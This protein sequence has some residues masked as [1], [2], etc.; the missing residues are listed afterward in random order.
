M[1][2][3]GKKTIEI[4]SKTE[5]GAGASDKT[6]QR[7]LLQNMASYKRAQD[8]AAKALLDQS[9]KVG[10][11]I[12]QGVKELMKT[13]LGGPGTSKETQE[14]KKAADKQAKSADKV[15]S[16]VDGLGKKVDNLISVIDRDIKGRPKYA[17]GTIAPGVTHRTE[18]VDKRSKEIADS[19]DKI[20]K[21]LKE[22][23]TSLITSARK[24]KAFEG[25]L[26]FAAPPGEKEPRLVRGPQGKDFRLEV[27][28]LDKLYKAID[29]LDQ[30]LR[31]QLPGRGEVTPEKVTK[32]LKAFESRL[33]ERATKDPAT[34]EE[35]A[36]AVAKVLQRQTGRR[37]TAAKVQEELTA[38]EI[39]RRYLKEVIPASIQKQLKE[40]V[41]TISVPAIKRTE[42]GL[43]VIET[44]SGAERGVGQFAYFKRGYEQLITTLQR[45]GK[46]TKDQ[47][48]EIRKE[49]FKAQ[50]RPGRG[51][52]PV[53]QE[54]L[55]KPFQQL[56]KL[57]AA[58]KPEQIQQAFARAI[59]TA[60]AKKKGGISGEEFE[61]RVAALSKKD[62]PEL[63]A[64]L[65]N[66]GGSVV[67]AVNALN[68]L[69]ELNL[70]D[71]LQSTLRRRV[72]QDPKKRTDVLEDFWRRMGQGQESAIRKLEQ[73]MGKLIQT[74]P[75][76]SPTKP[77]TGAVAEATVGVLTRKPG[78]A[79]GKGRPPIETTQLAPAAKKAAIVAI[80]EELRGYFAD[81]EAT[82]R[83]AESS[84]QRLSSI[85][86]SEVIA[87]TITN[88]EQ[89]YSAMF[90]MSA[91]DLR[92]LGPFGEQF[93]NLGRSL[94]QAQTAIS[95]P[96]AELPTLRSRTEQQFIESGRLGRGGFGYNV[97]TE[98]RHTAGTFEDQIEIAGKLAKV[99]T[100][101]ARKLV[102]PGGQEVETVEEGKIL[103]ESPL[104][105]A[106]GFIQRGE[107]IPKEILKEISDIGNEIITAFG[108]V[109]RYEFGAD[110]AFIESVVQTAVAARGEEVD[111]QI[112]KIV[113]QFVAQWGRKFTTRFAAKGVSTFGVGEAAA[114]GARIK[115]AED[116]GVARMPKT[117][118]ELASEMLGKMFP[119]AHE[120]LRKQL[121]AAGNK[122]FI[123]LFT[124]SE[125]EMANLLAELN[126]ALGESFAPDP[127]SIN[128]F[129]EMFTEKMGAGAEALY[130]EV[131]IEARISASGLVKRGLQSDILEQ[132]ANN[133]TGAVETVIPDKVDIEKWLGKGGVFA[134]YLGA[135]GFERNEE[136]IRRLTSELEKT[137]SEINEL[138]A[139]EV[140][141]DRKRIVQLQERQAQLQRQID[142]E[143]TYTAYSQVGGARRLVGE[144][145]LEIVEE[146]R[147][148]REATEREL[149]VGRKGLPIN[150][151]A[152]AAVQ[153]IFGESSAYMKELAESYSIGEAQ[154][155]ELITAVFLMSTQFKDLQGALDQA[156]PTIEAGGDAIAVF[157]KSA[158]DLEDIKDTILDMAKFPAAFGLQLPEAAGG[159]TLFVPGAVARGTYQEPETGRI[160]PAAITRYLD[161]MVE[162]SKKI[163]D[164]VTGKGEI[165]D[166]EQLQ[167]NVSV[168]FSRAINEIGDELLKAVKGEEVNVQ[169]AQEMVAKLIATLSET[170]AVEFTIRGDVKAKTERAAVEE[171]IA[172]RQKELPKKGF[173]VGGQEIVEPSE[174]AAALKALHEAA[175]VIKDIVVSPRGPKL[176]ADI[177]KI[178]AGI[179]KKRAKGEAVS[180]LESIEKGL[181][182]RERATAALE[183][184]DPA[185]VRQIGEILG[186]EVSKGV[187]TTFQVQLKRLATARAGYEKELGKAIFGK[188]GLVQT[189]LLEK[190]LP[191]VRGQVVALETDKIDDLNKAIRVMENVVDKLPDSAKN[192]VEAAAAI[193]AENIDKLRKVVEEA[194]VR[195]EEALA[196]GKPLL[197]EGEIAISVERAAKLGI[198]SALEE[199][200][201]V[202]V[203]TL[204]FPVTGAPSFQAAKARLITEEEGFAAPGFAEATFGL[205]GRPGY[206]TAEVLRQLEPLRKVAGGLR[207]DL[208]DLNKAVDDNKISEKEAAP[209]R[210]E[211]AGALKSL[212][213]I[214]NKATATFGPFEQNLDFDG[215]AIHVHAAK[216]K[217]AANEIEKHYLAIRDLTN[218]TMAVRQ[219]LF[220]AT[221][222]LEEP[223]VETL[224]QM[225]E[226]FEKRF[227]AVKGF[228]FLARPHIQEQVADIPTEEL[229]RILAAYTT[230]A[231]EKV[232]D[233]I[234]KLAGKLGKE[235]GA[236][237][238]EEKRAEI[239]NRKVA[240]DLVKHLSRTDVAPATEQLT[241]IARA[242]ESSVGFGGGL[243][244]GRGAGGEPPYAGFGFKAGAVFGEDPATAFQNRLNEILRFGINAAL[245]TKHGGDPVY[246]EFGVLLTKQFS[247]GQIKKTLADPAYG[248]LQKANEAIE[249]TIRDR[250]RGLDLE[251]IIE[252]AKSLGIEDVG[253]KSRRELVDAL[254]E[255]ANLVGFI[256]E[257]YKA[258]E[259]SAIKAQEVKITK[260]P[261]LAKK[262][263]TP[264]ERRAEAERRFLKARETAGGKGFKRIDVKSEITEILEPL[265]ILRTRGEDL[266]TTFAKLNKKADPQIFAPDWMK[267]FQEQAEE[268][269]QKLDKSYVKA[270]GKVRVAADHLVQSLLDMASGTTATGDALTSMINKFFETSEGMIEKRAR[271]AEQLGISGIPGQA[272][273]PEVLR[274]RLKESLIKAT[275]K[276]PTPQQFEKFLSSFMK[277]LGIEDIS[278][279]ERKTAELKGLEDF[280]EKA[281]QAG[282]RLSEMSEKEVEALQKMFIATEVTTAQVNR[283]AETLAR[284]PF[285]KF[286]AER[287]RG[288]PRRR[289][290]LLYGPGGAA[291]QQA[292]ELLGEARPTGPTGLAIA[293][294]ELEKARELMRG[295]PPGGGEFTKDINDLLERAL[296]KRKDAILDVLGGA[297]ETQKIVEE[298]SDEWD[299]AAADLL[300]KQ[301]LEG[302]G[303]PAAAAPPPPTG[304]PPSP[305]GGIGG[306]G[307]DIFTRRFK[308]LQAL[309]NEF[310]K[311]GRGL[312]KAGGLP[313]AFESFSKAMDVIELMR[314]ELEAASKLLDPADF[315]KKTEMLSA[316]IER[317]A[318][319]MEAVS[320]AQF[321][322]GGA[323]FGAPPT[324][325]EKDPDLGA[326]TGDTLRDL[327]G[328]QE[329]SRKEAWGD[330]AELYAQLPG[331]AQDILKKL[332]TQGKYK[333][334][335][336]E[337]K[338]ALKA[339]DITGGK[340]LD[341]WKLYHMSKVEYLIQQ[342]EQFK[343]AADEFE[344]AGKS[345]EMRQA[346]A[347]S[348]KFV[349]QAQEAIIENITKPRTSPYL[350]GGPKGVSG[351]L[352]STPLAEAAGIAIDP[353]EALGLVLKQK[354][355]AALRPGGQLA[356]IYNQIIKT[357]A[358]SK[359]KA[360]TAFKDLVKFSDD[361]AKSGDSIKE[362]FDFGFLADNVSILR[363]GVEKFL[364][365]NVKA[366]ETQRANLRETISL[367]KDLEKQ[368]AG[369]SRDVL[370]TEVVKVPKWL[371]PKQQEQLHKRNLA[372]IKQR[373]QE[374]LEVAKE[375]LGSYDAALTAIGQTTLYT[376][377][378][379]DAAGNV[380]ENKVHSFNKLSDT[381]TSSGVQVGRFTEKIEDMN[382]AFTERR[383]IGQAFRRVIMWGGAAA[384]VYGTIRA[385]REMVDTIADV[386]TGMVALR[387]V[388]NP[389][390]TDF[391]EMQMQAVQFAKEFG[392]SIQEVIASMRV[393]AQQGLNQV[394]VLDRART[395]TLAANVTVLQ[396]SDATEA[397][398]SA[399][400]QFSDEGKGSIK[401][402]DSWIEVAARHAITSKDL[403]LALQKAGSAAVNV[404]I[405]FNQLN[406]IVTGIGV[407]TRQ[408]GKEV[409]T[410]IR[411]IARRLTSAKAPTELAKIG[412]A[413][414]APTGDIRRAFDIF[415][416]LAMKWD[417]LTQVQ[418]LNI[419]MAI[420]G[421]RHYNSVLVLMKNWDEVLEALTHS[422]NSAGSAMRRNQI[423]M[424]SFRKKAEQLRQSII[425]IQLQFGKF[426]LGPAKAMI[427]SLRWMTERVAELP[428]GFKKA[429]L[430]IAAALVLA[431]KGAGVV[432][433]FAD[434]WSRI[435]GLQ[436]TPRKGGQTIFE[437]LTGGVKGITQAKSIFDVQSALGKL[438]FIAVDVG[439]SF[440]AL[441]AG[442]TG[443]AAKL[444]LITKIIKNLVVTLAGFATGGPILGISNII[445]NLL[446]PLSLLTAGLFGVS[447]AFNSWS[448][449]GTGVI[450]SLGPMAISIYGLYKTLGPVIKR[451][452]EANKTAS[453]FAEENKNVILS[454]Q[455]NIRNLN[456]YAATLDRVG[457]GQ[458]E[459]GKAR[460]PQ[461]ATRKLIEAQDRLA[462][463]LEKTIPS[464]ISHYDEF[465]RAVLRS[466]LAVRNTVES[467]KALNETILEVELT[468]EM[469][470]FRRE[471]T[472]TNEGVERTKKGLRDLL[473]HIPI[474]GKTLATYI[475]VAPSVDIK[476]VQEQLNKMLQVMREHP[477]S[478]V[479]DAPFARLTE[480][481]TKL[482]KHFDE[483]IKQMRGRFAQ[484]PVKESFEANAKQL[485][486]FQADF[487]IFANFYSRPGIAFNWTDFFAAEVFRREGFKI[488]ES[489]DETIAYLEE[490]GFK[491]KQTRKELLETEFAGDEGKFAEAISKGLIDKRQ[492]KRFEGDL[493]IFTRSIGDTITD[494]MGIASDTA[495]IAI[496]AAGN[497]I[498][499]Y[500]NRTT[501]ELEQIPFT[502]DMEKMARA[503][504]SPA[505]FQEAVTENLKAIDT[506]IAGAAAGIQYPGAI[507]LGARFFSQVPTEQRL[508]TTF[509]A[510]LE[511]FRLAAGPV[512]RGAGPAFGPQ[513]ARAEYEI[514]YDKYLTA[515]KAYKIEQEALSK[516]RQQDLDVTAKAAPATTKAFL[517]LQRVLLNETA[518]M[519][520]KAAVEDLTKVFEE[521]K[522]A[523]DD[524]KAAEQ[525]RLDAIQFTTGIL[526][527]LPRELPRTLDIP[528][529]L[530]ELSSEQLAARTTPGYVELRKVLSDQLATEQEALKRAT[531]AEKTLRDL[532]YLQLLYTDQKQTLIK[533]E[534]FERFTENVIAT[535]DKAQ[536]LTLTELQTHTEQLKRIA[537]NTGEMAGNTDPGVVASMIDKLGFGGIA[538]SLEGMRTGFNRFVEGPQYRR[539]PTPGELRA[540][541]AMQEVA[542]SI[543]AARGPVEILEELKKARE[544]GYG[545]K[546]LLPIFLPAFE[547]AL[548]P[549][550]TTE[551]VNGLVKAVDR[552]HQ[553][554]V[555]RAGQQEGGLTKAASELLKLRKEEISE[556]ILSTKRL[557]AGIS[558]TLLAFLAPKSEIAGGALGYTIADA[559]QEVL[560]V[561]RKAI[562]NFLGVLLGKSFS[563]FSKDRAKQDEEIQKLLEKV[564]DEGV[565]DERAKEI[566]EA[567]K[568]LDEEK[569]FRDLSL[570]EQAAQTKLL[571]KIAEDTSFF[572]KLADG[573]K[574]M[575]AE[576]ELQRSLRTRRQ[577]AAEVLKALG[578]GATFFIGGGIATGKKF[579]K[580]L[581]NLRAELGIDQARDTLEFFS[582]RIEAFREAIKGTEWAEQFDD[583]SK[584]LQKQIENIKKSPTFTD[585]SKAF[586]RERG[587]ALALLAEAFKELGIA[588]EGVGKAG[589][590]DKAVKV[591]KSIELEMFNFV[592]NL[593]MDEAARRVSDQFEVA[594]SGFM[595]GVRFPGAIEAG[596]PVQQATAAERVFARLPEAY[597]AFVTGREELTKFQQKLT[598][599]ARRMADA[600]FEIE[601][602]GDEG[603]VLGRE[604]DALSYEYDK[605]SFATTMLRDNLAELKQALDLQLI[606]EQLRVNV[607]D[608]LLNLKNQAKAFYDTTSIDV[609][610]QQHPLADV[611]P[612]WEQREFWRAG[613]DQFQLEMAQIRKEKGFLPFDDRRR[614]EWNREE[615][616]IQEKRAKE[617]EKF[618]AEISTAEGIYRQ[619]I[620]YQSRW[621]IDLQS[622]IDQVRS[623]LERAGETVRRGARTE[624]RG[625]PS[626][627]RLQQRLADIADEVREKEFEQ[628]RDK[629]QR[630]TEMLLDQ[631]LTVLRSID[632]GIK[633]IQFSFDEA[634]KG[635]PL[636]MKYDFPERNV[637]TGGGG[638][639]VFSVVVDGK[640]V[641]AQYQQ[642]GGFTKGPG[643][644]DNVPA[645]LTA[646]EYVIRKGSVDKLRKEQGEGFLDY[647]N[648]KGA[649]PGFQLGGIASMARK[650]VRGQ[651]EIRFG[652]QTGGDVFDMSMGELA[653]RTSFTRE[654]M[655]QI[656]AHNTMIEIRDRL[657]QEEKRKQAL[658]DRR[659]ARGLPA[660]RTEESKKMETAFRK[661]KGK[662][663]KYDY[664]GKARRAGGVSRDESYRKFV[665]E[666]NR[667]LRDLSE[668]E[669]QD[670]VAYYT[671]KQKPTT[672]LIDPGTKKT[673]QA[674][675]EQPAAAP[676]AAATPGIVQTL[677]NFPADPIK[678]VEYLTKQLVAA[679]SP[680]SP[681][682]DSVELV[683][684]LEGME[685]GPEWT[686]QNATPLDLS[687]MGIL[688]SIPALLALYGAIPALGDKIVFGAMDKF[689]GTAAGS[690]IVGIL[691]AMGIAGTGVTVASGGRTR[692]GS[693]LRNLYQ[694]F[695]GGGGIRGTLAGAGDKAKELYRLKNVYRRLLNMDK[696]QLI[697][698]AS[699]SFYGIREGLTRIELEKLS[700][701]KLIQ[702]IIRGVQGKTPDIPGMAAG[703]LVPGFDDGG[704]IGGFFRNIS[705]VGRGAQQEKARQAAAAAQKKVL[706]SVANWKTTDTMPVPDKYLQAVAQMFN[707][708]L[709]DLMAFRQEQGSTLSNFDIGN[710]YEL[711]RGGM[712]PGMFGGGRMMKRMKFPMGGLIPYKKFVGGGEV[713]D[714]E[715]PLNKVDKYAL[716]ILTGI[717]PG[718][719]TAKDI[720]ELIKGK[721]TFAGEELGAFGYG[722]TALSALVSLLPA[723]SLIGRALK[724]LGI[725]KGAFKGGHQAV[726]ALAEAAPV[727]SARFIDEF[728]ETLSAGKATAMSSPDFLALLE[729]SG[730]FSDARAAYEML[731]SQG[732]KKVLIDPA[733]I[734][735]GK[736][737]VYEPGDGI[738]RLA[739]AFGREGGLAD[740]FLSLAHESFHGL[741]PILKSVLGTAAETVGTAGKPLGQELTGAS[742]NILRTHPGLSKLR[743]VVAGLGAEGTEWISWMAKNLEANYIKQP[744]YWP[745]EWGAFFTRMINHP[746]IGEAIR[747]IF[748]EDFGLP[749]GMGGAVKIP[750]FGRGS[751]FIPSP[752]LA[753]LHGGEAIIPASMNLGGMA[754]YQAGGAV[755]KDE[756]DYE[757]ITDAVKA[758]VEAAT[759][760]ARLANDTVQLANDTVKAVMDTASIE[761]LKNTINTA[762]GAG[763]DNADRRISFLE[764]KAPGWENQIKDYSQRLTK[765]ELEDIPAM[766]MDIQT[767]VHDKTEVLRTDVLNLQAETGATISN[768]TADISRINYSQLE[769]KRDQLETK[770][771]VNTMDALLQKVTADLSRRE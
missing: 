144:K 96:Q 686:F 74:I 85:G 497:Q 97:V 329:L 103:R 659:V 353:E 463:Q 673:T 306:G 733:L 608:A 598:D 86:M 101:T 301:K 4:V 315:Q 591:V 240:E 39:S 149:E 390:T 81:L 285:E 728:A 435:A 361:L 770:G 724:G 550:A 429:T 555:G 632:S 447:A 266:N 194:G 434:A 382:K 317:I 514:E 524:A 70:Y 423:V 369:V 396:A 403:A 386:E 250:L 678:Q 41:Q 338:D 653:D 62:I 378:I 510:N 699:R 512:G 683:E 164:A 492:F 148:K 397:L 138:K 161:Q 199:G 467:L 545:N 121:V 80:N 408:T 257:L 519:N 731:I 580:Q 489:G 453:Q 610:R 283:L 25:K 505:Q 586:D 131:P 462:I 474:V 681:W 362:A 91:L 549:K 11:E 498:L 215:D 756:P 324:P 89:L 184:M 16:S 771:K 15:T 264:E 515:L 151:H 316:V 59:A 191:A 379:F 189:A 501:G 280:D 322:A 35:M 551:S 600:R 488:K 17:P 540:A 419:S 535:G 29:K 143:E 656:A 18:E 464:A 548:G 470:R 321:E 348:K 243:I 701:T 258:L 365:Q 750:S 646:G 244:G 688:G 61:A 620:D 313:E 442:I 698:Q 567:V 44:K 726:A 607:S 693:T 520:Y 374:P 482:R 108:E 534:D 614:I 342:A 305:P 116:L 10:Q 388:M 178:E 746:K 757:A 500:F 49:I 170:R 401:F 142:L 527:G 690:K 165:L 274:G 622:I 751:K 450:A 721:S 129:K 710:A 330:Y 460:L 355:F 506:I 689:A 68:R 741:K 568:P 720:Y 546:E 562:Y 225:S 583:A 271:V 579:E 742:L 287:L 559:I 320:K 485:R 94:A 43:Q 691:E 99:L 676:S 748:R 582:E 413:A 641:T 13:Q 175:L 352:R 448:N 375:R 319:R 692:I 738:I 389:V 195:R 593:R 308:E 714:P 635:H 589:L 739:P 93:A 507:D 254:V 558:T 613:M 633:S 523:L 638:P 420:G 697:Q 42:R 288:Q 166:E 730:I 78:I 92:K 3:E 153:S 722:A 157:G 247:A 272:A 440:N 125:P 210:R 118:G 55:A 323:A 490:L 422:Q 201:E 162:A 480:Q 585:P 75:T 117:M 107:E 744:K 547:K 2:D 327:R 707:L 680:K 223:N 679:S 655:E 553:G 134:K 208:D 312:E 621:G 53:R 123:D 694:S 639:Q 186:A 578:I 282:F 717:I 346:L 106:R 293:P 196:A 536:G 625:V 299:Q 368:Y 476:V 233:A 259:E 14:V 373:L 516:I 136:E 735:V 21:S 595:A 499:E 269:G 603:G 643:G 173:K 31:K 190:R 79:T 273:D 426:A 357:Q 405:D 156:L 139:S 65:S 672:A 612:Q 167:K 23:E 102:L 483:N 281:A 391:G 252:E 126:T 234:N 407:T 140:E 87:D 649:I 767:E 354:E 457:K 647:L 754:G 479:W 238:E 20:A 749:F 528:T 63:Q 150:V 762:V 19:A 494:G 48:D 706:D 192:A 660:E 525:I 339:A 147:L 331:R 645:M 465:G 587:R 228:E 127:A 669:F 445:R 300:Q 51:G 381:V 340:E 216:T 325:G 539:E 517:D 46:V 617:L 286:V 677:A 765:I 504:F 263:V 279:I 671:G 752:Q 436:L 604:L 438:G 511:A 8:A 100:E 542:V 69:K 537:E 466:D 336:A 371:D 461:V 661:A 230:G 203:E 713:F 700:K 56:V 207:A 584:T 214:I 296:D 183:R 432:D 763:F 421:R 179:A 303:A 385:L 400:K 616:L 40:I 343:K 182:R 415:D 24:S 753:F 564:A 360:Q 427:D 356:D 366:T 399:T 522:M 113:E 675:G 665:E 441:V 747:T 335:P 180:K 310:Y 334:A 137:T 601:K 674:P 708:D 275:G 566:L 531:A 169:K 205:A 657:I 456:N 229:D 294:R 253:D 1:A 265:Y 682:T 729:K 297:E 90:K 197:K 745:E 358:P 532:D 115:L 333:R 446:D 7:Q 114:G 284:V 231:P 204:R 5:G 513:P 174:Q 685:F 634:G 213:T 636:Q 570:N 27:V 716:D 314:K 755:R 402:L 569:S 67:D 268:S 761:G 759:L 256:Q 380:I 50:A 637:K 417:T 26:Q 347:N 45:S 345:V 141:V 769:I 217:E 328:Y 262:F 418:R 364:F 318:E 727:K 662:L 120:D 561:D 206:D 232:E 154:A 668:Q 66:L 337:F 573:D 277:G 493:V 430:A 509:G 104:F 168:G 394:E 619:L 764:G 652:F 611:R 404:G 439:R 410:S 248:G 734:K 72:S 105:K 684:G 245:K 304:P 54:E 57:V 702:L 615:A 276:E 351:R 642:A 577:G 119:G 575:L 609:A 630:P 473:A 111:V 71:L 261:E 496:D 560:G 236:I 200:K 650:A 309:A 377:K 605:V 629:V 592:K 193:P 112:A 459:L 28:D 760:E 711:F 246:K 37:V 495:R 242:A 737:G 171:Y 290:G 109:K 198:L 624:F 491:T 602:T 209:R 576:L 454:I 392:V 581:E 52:G 412:V 47:L 235:A 83:Q 370:E 443:S 88:M 533:K 644:I 133:L 95:G 648:Q 395:S 696:E 241:R 736:G 132:F 471:L 176:T 705:S 160:A 732:L 768:V 458:Q 292:H 398:T 484:L 135:L 541:D 185:D 387:K 295:T 145:F 588:G 350:T 255:K 278:A 76:V 718:I 34:P 384:V 508:A 554:I 725:S 451:W 36:A 163:Q 227:P 159:E 444:V 425:E 222:I 709:E 372:I 349:E 695:K 556:S 626:L 77:K 687:A 367:L 6:T 618:N 723:G 544:E 740:F 715:Q 9:K 452:L 526:A 212:N 291:L 202:F 552:L 664:T 472:A 376:M 651:N 758:G 449:T 712:V 766:K 363:A 311:E 393:F 409:G 606:I 475:N 172:L 477:L 302:P 12:K 73:E 670:K 594:L 663:T 249:E 341:A 158:G 239:F 704:G 703:G 543:L 486:K 332:E 437:T 416:E 478:T 455:E 187:G 146:P 110:K 538:A 468:E 631:Q 359:V 152:F 218:D 30:Q 557:T 487:Q 383:G 224:A 84:F 344:Q 667:A 433:R 226:I 155:Q 424:E 597:T 719:G 32:I 219:A 623:D 326:V 640:D 181:L 521:S 628:M 128:R 289:G 237:T 518:V 188:T 627:D 211:L 124:S 503:I 590:A 307:D 251:Q 666:G 64:S 572:S 82:G 22:L 658:R 60:E 571:A 122:F 220:R 411:F 428:G 565:D 563:E 270:S 654:E 743:D 221:A 502:T 599:L 33:L 298:A 431:H 414:F 530:G 574:K 177:R 58:Q 98:L 529:R 406:A 481:M 38:P 130:K 267:D 260:D 469:E 596:R